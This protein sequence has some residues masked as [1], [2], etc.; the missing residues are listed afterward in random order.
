VFDLYLFR[1]FLS[2]AYEVFDV[3][4]RVELRDL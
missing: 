2:D 3:L 1:Q 4:D